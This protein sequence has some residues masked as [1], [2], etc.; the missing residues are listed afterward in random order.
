MTCLN[1]GQEALGQADTVPKLGQQAAPDRVTSGRKKGDHPQIRPNTAISYSGRFMCASG[2]PLARSRYC[3]RIEIDIEF[4]CHVERQPSWFYR[5]QTR[6]SGGEMGKTWWWG[7]APQFFV[8]I[9]RLL[10]RVRSEFFV[11]FHGKWTVACNQE[12]NFYFVWTLSA[13]TMPVL[14]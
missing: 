13:S 7:F 12:W 4:I 8:L 1:W 6:S 14:S 9:N 2:S 3:F 10:R 11:S 5:N